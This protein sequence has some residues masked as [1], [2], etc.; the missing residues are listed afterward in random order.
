M[1]PI[2]STE[3][4]IMG[5]LNANRRQVPDRTYEADRGTTPAVVAKTLRGKGGDRKRESMRHQQH[6]VL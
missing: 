5:A 1:V 3:S 4:G 2:F 6:S